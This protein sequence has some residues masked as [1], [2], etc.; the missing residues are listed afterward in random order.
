VDTQHT[1]GSVDGNVIDAFN[2]AHDVRDV[3]EA[4]GYVF[5]PRDTFIRPGSTNLMNGHVVTCRDGR[6]RSI[7][8]STSDPLNDRKFGKAVTCGVCDAF[9]AFAKLHHR[10]STS[11][12]VHAA[13]ALL[14][15]AHTPER[16]GEVLL[17]VAD[18]PE[19]QLVWQAVHEITDPDES[20]QLAR[21]ALSKF[22]GNPKQVDRLVNV[23]MAQKA[24]A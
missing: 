19:A 17:R 11:A 5:T 23:L 10:G 12:A 18:S 20:R 14:G 1:R 8:F 3:L 16:D 6:R 15:M 4:A 9:D 2:A 7:H 13:A 22:T 21:T 24:V